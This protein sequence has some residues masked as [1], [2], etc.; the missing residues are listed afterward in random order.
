MVHTV[1]F[2]RVEDVFQWPKTL[3]HFSMDPELVDQAELMVGDEMRR[4]YHSRHW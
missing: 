4:W 1:M 3:N 2:G